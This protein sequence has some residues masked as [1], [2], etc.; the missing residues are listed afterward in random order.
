LGLTANRPAH[1]AMQRSAGFD[2]LRIH[3]LRF[4]ILRLSAA[5]DAPVP[6]RDSDKYFFHL[7]G[8]IFAKGA[9][10]GTDVSFVTQ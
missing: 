4:I 6:C 2:P 7:F 1:R 5:A 3:A 8:T 9:F 10:I